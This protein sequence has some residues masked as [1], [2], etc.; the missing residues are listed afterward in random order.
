ME[1]QFGRCRAVHRRSDFSLRL[2]QLHMVSRILSCTELLGGNV[3]LTAA[4][5]PNHDLLGTKAMSHF[6]HAHLPRQRHLARQGRQLR[7]FH[8][9]LRVRRNPSLSTPLH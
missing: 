7:E 1:L 3:M 9:R 5:G 6:L 2:Q 4:Q 8:G